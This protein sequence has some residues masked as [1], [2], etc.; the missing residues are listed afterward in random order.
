MRKE[1][2]RRDRRQ[3]ER[4]ID[5]QAEREYKC[6]RDNKIKKKKYEGREGQRQRDG[7]VTEREMERERV[8]STFKF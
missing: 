4:Q 5:R 6:G 7:G 3:T 8:N 1:K 2:A